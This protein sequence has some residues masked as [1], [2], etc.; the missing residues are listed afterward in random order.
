VRRKL[1]FV[2]SLLV[3][4]AAVLFVWL[5]T[6]ATTP[7]ALQRR[8]AAMTGARVSVASVDRLWWGPGAKLHGLQLESQGYVVDVDG[9]EVRVA[10]LPL[11]WGEVTPR[12]IDVRDARLTLRGNQAGGLGLPALPWQAAWTIGQLDIFGEV[13]GEEEQLFH[14][15]QASLET[16]PVGPTRLEIQGGATAAKAQ[17]VHIR[18][19][20]SGWPL[21]GARDKQAAA[22]P[23]ANLA[24]DIEDLPA[25]P[26]LGFLSGDERVLATA[27][28]DGLLTLATEPQTLIADGRLRAESPAE[29]ELLALQFRLQSTGERL[30]FQS[31]TGRVAGNRVVASGEG[32]WQPEGWDAQ[33]EAQL[34][35][36][37]IDNDTLRLLHETLGRN[38]LGFADHLR[39]RFTAEMKLAASPQ[40]G[41]M[42]GEV[43]LGGMTYAAP[44]LPAVRDLRGR[45]EMDGSRVRFADVSARVFD[46]PVKLGGEVRGRQLALQAHTG[47]VPLGQLPLP[48]GENA[49]VKNFTGTAA[50]QV[51]L[52]GD[53]DNPQVEGRLSLAEAGFDFRQVEIREVEG[54]AE[55]DL[56]RVQFDGVRGR[57]GGCAF[58]LSGGFEVP[59]WR[60]SAR[61]EL[62][63]PGCELG[64]LFLLAEGAGL[65]SLPLLNAEALG[66][67][68]DLSLQYAQQ[69]WQATLE[70]V[71][72]RWSPAWLAL[73]VEGIEARLEVTPSRLEFS[74]LQGRLGRSP[75]SLEGHIDLAAASP[76]WALELTTELEPED[77]E[78]ILHGRGPEWVRFPEAI[79]GSARLA[80][81]AEQGI[82]VQARFEAPLGGEGNAGAAD[83]AGGS[84]R[85]APS[86][87]PQVELEGVWRED[88]FTLDD[89][90]ATV[91]TTRVQGRGTLRLQPDRQL[92]LNVHV[93]PGSS[94]AELL[95]FVRLPSALRSIEGTV[96]A[97]VGV[98]GPPDQLDWS[99]AIDLEE[100]HIPDLLTEPVALKGR[101]DISNDGLRLQGIE[102]VQPQGTFTLAGVVRPQGR[103][104]LRLKGAWANLDRLLGQW[105]EEKVVVP[106]REALARY[107][108]RVGLDV[109]EVQFLGVVFKN[110]EGQAE[111]NGGE[112]SLRVPRFGIDSGTGSLEVNPLPGTDRVRVNLQLEGV[113][114]TVFLRDLMKQT[115]AVGGPLALQA[116]LT[117][118]LG[119]GRQDFLQ[120]AEGE[121]AFQLGAGRFQRGTLPERLFALAVMLEEGLYGFGL[122]RLA[123]I[124]KPHDLDHF[125]EWNGRV[126]VGEG[127]ARVAESHLTSKVYDVDMTGQVE[128]AGGQ[129]KLHGDGNFHPGWE[130]DI[131]LKAIVNVFMRLFRLARGHR[132]HNFEFDV[133]GSLGGRKSVEN[134]RFTN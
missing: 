113:P 114:M 63:M 86:A 132:G 22:L 125:Q 37:H 43:R 57:V 11:L 70:V 7:E 93:P 129:L 58:E 127:T 94:I 109:D 89:F 25:Q 64:K 15:A 29:E 96:G 3:A 54:E 32:R 72:G 71:D 79:T 123:R 14:I 106:D 101:A 36:G 117:G 131:S 102:V 24:L 65:G 49:P 34:P 92:D 103:S 16:G 47:E 8:L 134:F 13:G 30:L 27:R 90:S 44:G 55:F 95:T 28:L 107:P 99:G 56:Q 67:T 77:A 52:G 48:L 80:G 12:S 82:R 18:G 88:T 83:D 19:E 105:P 119:G 42:A 9:L 66:G 61:A 110:V 115:P 76:A 118:P 6:A 84:E 128:L 73:P 85:A 130:F 91:G 87:P 45:L 46:I 26:L 112:L 4:L 108:V 98:A 111:Q 60:D 124:G 5:F 133:G 59:A 10:F 75:V 104:E 23:E 2:F 100:V 35:E 81:S 53:M 126:A 97:D 74:R 122:N 69:E 20:A 68:G 21:V 39:G 41:T 62:E 121:I 17:S 33:A 38:V 50:V 78:R 40:G 116:Q 51:M 120:E 1:I 31:A